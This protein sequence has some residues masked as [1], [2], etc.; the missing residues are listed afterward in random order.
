MSSQDNPNKSVRVTGK[1]RLLA[2]AAVSKSVDARVSMFG[3]L[4]M[5]SGLVTYD[6]IV[7][8]I[9][10]QERFRSQGQPAPKLGEL[11]VEKG[12]ITDKDVQLILKMQSNPSG[13][14]GRQLIERGLVSRQQLRAALDEQADLANAGITPPRIGEMLVEKGILKREDLQSLVKKKESSSHLLGEFLVQNKL[15][16]QEDLDKCLQYQKQATDAG[17]KPPRLGDLLVQ[18]GAVRKEQMELYSRRH[19]QARRQIAAPVA[20]LTALKRTNRR[21]LGEY[22]IIDTLGQHMDGVT[23]RAVHS[24][25][26]AVVVMHHFNSDSESEF[27]EAAFSNRVQSAISLR[28][29]SMQMIV[30][31]DTI[32]GHLAIVADFIEGATL[33]KVV[34]ETGKIQWPWAAEIIHEI[35]GV[36]RSAEL[37]AI[38][39]DDIRPGSILVD[40]KGQAHLSLWCY[41]RDSVANRDWLAKKHHPI[42]FYFAPERLRYGP[43]PQADIFSLG[44]TIIHAMTGTPPLRGNSAA[45]AA[46]RFTSLE[47][48][49]DVAIDMD[50]PLDFINILAS[51]VEEDPQNRPA[52]WADLQMT[53]ADF[54]ERQG[55]EP[56]AIGQSIAE[57]RQ[58]TEP[59]AQSI[60]TKY[61]SSDIV[62]HE[63]KRV[64]YRQLFRLFLGPVAAMLLIMAGMTI[65]YK[66]TQA[67]QGLMVRANWLDQHGDKA[68]AL[69][70]Y[71]MI[72]TIY[73]ANET[74]QQRY[75][76][77]AMEVRDHGE[78]E[79]ALERLMPFRPGRRDDLTELQADLQVWQRRFVSATE[80]Y[81]SLSAQRPTDLAL[82]TKLANAYLWGH[83]Y[84][85]AVREFKQLVAMS[86]SDP[87]ALLG[88][89]R[90]AAGVKDLAVATDTFDRLLRM[91][92]LPEASVMEYAWLLSDQGKIDKLREVAQ[93]VLSRTASVEYSRQNQT[94]LNYWAGNYERARE[95][96][97]SLSGMIGTDE[98]SIL[99]RIDINDKM[100]NYDQMIEDYRRL[101]DMN[102]NNIEYLLTIARLHQARQ[103]FDL[104]DAAFRAALARGRD[105]VGVMREIAANL[106]YMNKRDE[107]IE[108]YRKILAVAPGDKQAANALVEML[109]WNEN[110]EEAQ[111]YV[112]QIHRDNPTDR[113]ARVNL[114]L[115]YS[116][117]GR[118][119]EAMPIVDELLRKDEL[120]EDE[121]ERIALNA[122][123]S[124][125]NQLMLRLIGDSVA[126]NTRVTELRLMLARRM[127]AA[128][129]HT[130]ALPLYAAVLAATPNPDPALLMEMAESANWAKR[131]DIATRWLELAARIVAE[132]EGRSPPPN[133]DSSRRFML[134][135]RDWESIL[136]PLRQQP[137][138]HR[139]IS[140]FGEQFALDGERELGL[141]KLDALKNSQ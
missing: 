132:R 43:T 109:L 126:T 26:G 133:G 75:F 84:E 14:I 31:E 69:N 111:K 3:R 117:L 62:H 80:L 89:A 131:P 58:M 104:A 99:F 33:D 82:R 113:N 103:Q 21:T 8:C 68:G 77:L 16:G 11:L 88:L 106:G 5:E 4:A 78:A 1:T 135:E 15:I 114:A 42:P 108:E 30:S 65:A 137:A 19:A 25:S 140:G 110:Y 29:D 81:R 98:Q 57:T 121:K 118:E 79:L 94:S 71:R 123:Q 60:L 67:S 37:M 120:T 46:E 40:L 41:T 93:N 2:Q 55:M 6:E 115:V 116:R 138:I 128:S 119:R 23:F 136:E 54:L 51:L 13:L 76:D 95:L 91:D 130:T 85:E 83:N 92:M 45:D 47:V 59:E 97:D 7:A 125:S 38:T 9:E 87:A 22:E 127:R 50:L 70:L 122:M 63:N 72:S 86:P 66:T 53:M 96:L 17:K 39:H 141:K 105:D 24:V 48:M 52:N 129:R 134:S 27:A 49:Q 90:A 35:A 20:S 124:N 74:V 56:G 10:E 100:K 73:P 107:A 44:L 36:M 28:G 102:P 34:Q 139:A 12:I 18:C 101:S 61:L 64:T 112:E 32:S